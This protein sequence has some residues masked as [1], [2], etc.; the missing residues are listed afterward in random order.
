MRRALLLL[1]AA[2]GLAACA[3]KPD[4]YL[5]PPAVGA[6]RQASA[7][8]VAVAD[9]SLPAYAETVEIAVLN[10]TGAVTLSKNAL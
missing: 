3:G 1:L 7:G 5:T 6:D 2:L 4:Y 9:M 10:E 8:S